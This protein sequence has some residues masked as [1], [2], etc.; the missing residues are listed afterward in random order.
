MLYQHSA[1]MAVH[2]HPHREL[3]INPVAHTSRVLV[4]ILAV[5]L[6]HFSSH[7]RA[8]TAPVTATA[9][10]TAIEEAFG[11]KP[12]QRRNHTKGVC[13]EGQF[14]GSPAIVPF[15]RSTLFSSNSVPVVAR[16][17]LAGGNAEA[18]DTTK[19]PRGMALEF[20]LPGG[21]LQHIT[22]LNTPVFGA[23]TPQTFVDLHR[24]LKPDPNTGKPDPEKMKAFRA[25]HPDSLAQA[26]F[27]ASHNP[28]TS[29]ANSTYFGIH[30]F[31]F[32]NQEGKTTLVRWRFSPQ[33]GE[34]QLSDAELK[35][36]PANFLEQ[37]LIARTKTGPLRW[38][39]LVSIGEPGD[40]EDD[41]TVA[42]P[43]NRKVIE[44]G[45]L[46]LSTAQPQQGGV[47]EKIN[48]DPLVMADG[49]APTNDPILLFRSPAYAVSFGKRLNGN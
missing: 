10:V 18:P 30:T 46:T 35:S 28:P 6:M 21:A 3:V 24:A 49:I 48:F 37:D 39:M 17:S 4:A 41:P 13:A 42:W 9:A 2:R 19:N 43:E 32:I 20:R 11:V 1:P 25:S 8:E 34:R 23:K 14:V 29:F 38:N 44:A 31:K 33:D 40:V 7:C 26:A 15:S 45:T 16:F 12:G 5:G 36:A 27:L 22:M 47:C